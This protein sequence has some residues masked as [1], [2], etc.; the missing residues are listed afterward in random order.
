MNELDALLQE[1]ANPPKEPKDRPAVAWLKAQGLYEWVANK[2]LDQGYSVES[3]FQTI[4]KHRGF[5]WE[6]T[7]LREIVRAMRREKAA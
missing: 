1:E 3:V 4:K 2:V 6:V 7:T 5:S